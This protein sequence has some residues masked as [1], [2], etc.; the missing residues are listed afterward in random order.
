VGDKRMKFTHWARNLKRDIVAIWIAARDPR[1][2]ILAKI[3]AGA[4]AAYAFS[5][6]DLIP[7]FIPVLGYVDDIIIVPLGIWLALR[8]IPEPLMT[9]FRKTASIRPDRPTSIVAAIAI[10]LV[11]LACGVLIW[12]AMH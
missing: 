11:W 2:P 3:I 6:I 7:D 10:I 12:R 1:T 4:T 9:E 8:L 5:P